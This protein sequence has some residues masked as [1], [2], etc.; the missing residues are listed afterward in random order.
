MLTIVGEGRQNQLQEKE[1]ETHVA[2]TELYR[3]YLCWWDADKRV[4]IQ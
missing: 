4:C 3:V 1:M 2:S